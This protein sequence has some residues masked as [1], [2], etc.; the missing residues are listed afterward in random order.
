MS[1]RL[2]ARHAIYRAAE[3]V[4]AALGAFTTQPNAEEALYEDPHP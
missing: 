4:V 2:K 3:A 1:R